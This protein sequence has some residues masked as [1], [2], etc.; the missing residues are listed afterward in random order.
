MFQKK[1]NLIDKDFSSS[2]IVLNNDFLK[3][4]SNSEIKTVY[5]ETRYGMPAVHIFTSGTEGNP[6]AAVHSHEAY[7]RKSKQVNYALPEGKAGDKFLGIIPFFSA[8]GSFEGMNNCICRA[9]N[10]IM[11]PSFKPS[12]VPELICEYRPNTIIAV[13]NYWHDFSLRIEDLMKKYGI[14]DLSFLKYPVSGGDKQP[15]ADII[16]CNELFKKYGSSAR[17]IRGYGSTEVAGAIATTIINDEYED[18]EYT[19]VLLPGT[20][21]KLMN[22][23]TGKIDD[24]INEGE[25]LISD[26]AML[27]EYLNNE[28]ANKNNILEIDGDRYFN[29][30]DIFKIDEKERLH[31]KG[32]IKRVMMRPDGHTV[33]ALPIEEVL[34]NSG[35]V[36]QCCVVG[37]KSNYGTGTIPTAFVKLKEEMQESEDLVQVLDK[38]A[39]KELS[40]RNRALAYVFVDNIPKT[41][42]DKIDYKKLEQF[43]FEDL[44]AYVVDDIFLQKQSKNKQKVMTN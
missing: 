28:E 21:Y 9:M 29:M 12:E 39:L 42:M 43:K 10:I 31:F 2:R 37:L 4:T 35:Y 19:G 32:R 27:I 5:E 11:I 41:L 15:S 30:G 36:D 13:P 25:L 6:K 38:L 20:K 16:E 44:N 34:E 14:K 24:S 18:N 40:E 7:I 22:I 1:L 26:P 17:L 8:Y 33:H 23:E 3:N